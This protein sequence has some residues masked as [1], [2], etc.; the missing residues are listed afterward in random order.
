[1][2]T[3]AKDRMDILCPTFSS[4]S[5]SALTTRT[6][7]KSSL[8][9]KTRTQLSP[10]QRTSSF[11][12]CLQILWQTLW[13]RRRRNVSCLTWTGT[14]SQTMQAH[15]YKHCEVIG[16]SAARHLD[17]AR[18][19]W[20]NLW[21]RV[22]A[23]SG[24]RNDSVFVWMADGW[25]WK[26]GD[27]SGK[28][29]AWHWNVGIARFCAPAGISISEGKHRASHGH[30]EEKS[31]N[32]FVP[33]KRHH[34]A[35]AAVMSWQWRVACSWCQFCDETGCCRF[36]ANTLYLHTAQHATFFELIFLAQVHRKLNAV[37]SSPRVSQKDAMSSSSYL[38]QTPTQLPYS[39]QHPQ[40]ELDRHQQ[41]HTGHG[42]YPAQRPLHS[43][44][45]RGRS[46]EQSA[47][48]C[49]GGAGCYPFFLVPVRCRNLLLL[50][51]KQC[52]TLFHV[53]LVP[54][55]RTYLSVG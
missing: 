30:T 48:T 5:M 46:A 51:W 19:G 1:M 26:S 28:A 52:L 43:V 9:W 49:G 35:A 2:W 33:P 53:F 15:G 24:G 27:Y 25:I 36:G 11:I 17:Q 8:T 40:D 23:K 22:A 31:S 14:E 3:W 20:W 10:I 39:L 7:S 4:W 41:R 54:V 13:P 32:F 21:T 44:G 16:P 42:Q 45:L 50:G 12:K 55:P 38:T 34:T 18:G 47:C 29:D 6:S 37:T